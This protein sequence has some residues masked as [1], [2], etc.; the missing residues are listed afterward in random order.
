MTRLVLPQMVERKKG[1]IIN[2]ASLGGA[3]CTPLLSVYSAT[4][5]YVDSEMSRQF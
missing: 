5:A 3:V 1:A 4:K 2:L